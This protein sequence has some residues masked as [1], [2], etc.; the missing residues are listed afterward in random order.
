[1][2]DQFV[3]DE[4]YDT[5]VD[6]IDKEHE[7]LFH[8]LNKLFDFGRQEEKSHWVCREAV[9]YFK[10]HALQHFA[11]EEDYM[12]SVHYAGLSTHKRI[13]TNFRER[14]LPALERELERTNYSESSVNHFLDVCAGWLVRHTLTEDH[15]IVSGDTL[16]HWEKLLPE[17]AQTVMGQ[18][19]ASLLHSMFQLDPQLL[20]S[21]YSGERFG[22]GIYYRLIYDTK[23][24]GR[25]EM[26][27][28]L[29]EQMI[30]SMTGGVIGS[31]N[32]TVN[33]VLMNVAVY[34]ARQL[35]ERIMS[36]FPIS[37]QFQ[38]RNEHLLSYEQFQRIYEKQSPQ[39]S[40]LFD[41]GKGYFA[42]CAAAT[43][44][45]H[46]E[47]GI[48]ILT[49]NAMMEAEKYF[50]QHKETKT[51]ARKKKKLLVVDDSDFMLKALQSLLDS[52]Y[53]VTT[54]KSGL[55]A[56]REITLSRPDL[57]LLDYEMPVCNGRQ[58]LEMI[59]SEKEFMDIPVIFLT[60]RV[61]QESVK[62][63]IAL[64]PEGYLLKSQPAEA[65]KKEIDR[66]FERK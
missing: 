2:G 60:N 17:D 65:V 56:I 63:A 35:A 42:Y 64:R 26:F 28:I 62:R 59:R 37:E 27:L 19:I 52:D 41:T 39:F 22:K 36:C 49:E 7:K 3:W 13:H 45:I 50:N 66:F 32:K 12:A 23:D 61:D 29:E 30:V 31:G 9:K 38:V 16:K 47:G 6:M 40:L 58:V 48:I 20:S 18:T 33:V 15:M 43:G 44:F 5:G 1:M 10:D 14:M 11:D 34:V 57:V 46:S 25:L 53:E 24:G 51:A 21:C 55:S 54:A 4:R 8:I